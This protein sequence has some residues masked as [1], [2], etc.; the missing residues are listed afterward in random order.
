MPNASDSI[1]SNWSIN[2]FQLRQFDDSNRL[3]TLLGVACQRQ[4]MKLFQIHMVKLEGRWGGGSS[5]GDK[6]ITSGTAGH[7]ALGTWL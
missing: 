7:L 4:L 3:S 2:D 6:F 1:A 5:A